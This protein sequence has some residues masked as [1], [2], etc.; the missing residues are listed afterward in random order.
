[1]GYL[2]VDLSATQ[3]LPDPVVL[4]EQAPLLSAA[5][6]AF[7]AQV[8][9]TADKWRVLGVLYETPQSSLVLN[10]MAAPAW[11]AQAL[12][13]STAAAARAISDFAESVR[14]IRTTRT[15]L[16]IEI[17]AAENDLA[18]L[19]GSEEEPVGDSFD[20]ALFNYQT[21]FTKRADALADAYEQARAACLAALSGIRRASSD[22]SSYYASDALDLVS[23]DVE[24]LHRRAVSSGATPEDVQ[25]YYDALA[26]MDPADYKD[27]AQDYPEAAVYPPRIGLAADQQAAF[28]QSLTPEQQEALAQAL[29]AVVGN[30]EGVPYGLRAAANAAV[31]A[32]VMKPSWRATDEQRAAYKSINASLG[33]R[34]TMDPSGR[35]LIAFD[36]ADPPLAAV[37]IGNMDTATNVTMNVSGMD[38]S[39]QDM[40]G[41][42]TAANNIYTQQE[43]LTSGHAVVAWI[44]YDSPELSAEVLYSDKARTGGAKLATVIDGLYYT[45]SSDIPEVSVTA[46]SYGTTT[47]AYALSQTTHTVDTVV[48]YGS[49]GIDPEAARTAADLNAREVYATQGSRDIVAPGGI[50]GSELGNPRLSPTA[51]AFGAKVFSSEVDEYGRANGGHSVEGKETHA[52]PHQTEAGGGYLDFGTSSLAQIAE[53]STGNGSSLDLIPQSAMDDRVEHLKETTE[54]VYYGPGRVVDNMQTFG[55]HTVDT[56]QEGHNRA[57]DALQDGLVQVS[58]VLQDHYLPDFGPFENPLDPFVDEKQREAVENAEAARRQHNEIVDHGQHRVEDIVDTQQKEADEYFKRRLRVLEFHAEKLVSNFR[59]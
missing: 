1:M 11:Q 17:N 38:S 53:A 58:D 28:W 14:T 45:R 29:P 40:E 25:C 36:P 48:F 56:L 7:Q 20:N 21:D 5:G 27:Y 16:Q 35:S 30:T 55:E 51:E 3:T 6:E 9:D 37:A 22:A 4:Q 54:D 32:L 33:D 10:A 42:V 34:N 44:G 46:H 39:S 43:R 50:A 49:A 59:D 18:S 41:A 52:L 12:T 31:L 8:S 13:A 19:L 2:Y 47:A 26:A 15:D 24:R 23:H 57:A